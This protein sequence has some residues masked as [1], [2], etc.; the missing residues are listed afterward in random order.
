MTSNHPVI[1]TIP[2][3]GTAAIRKRYFRGP[4]SVILHLVLGRCSTNTMLL[5]SCASGVG[6]HRNRGVALTLARMHVITRHHA[7]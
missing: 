6:R 1:G 5:Q 3:R 2:A 4:R 7:K